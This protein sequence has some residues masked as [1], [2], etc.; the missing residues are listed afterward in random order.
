MLSG[1]VFQLRPSAPLTDVTGSSPLLPTP[2]SQSNGNAADPGRAD[3]RRQVAKAKHGRIFGRGLEESL[4]LLPTPMAR[5]QSGTQVSGDSRTGG[6]M[7]EEALKLLPTP[8][9]SLCNYGEEPETWEPRRAAAAERHGNN[10]IGMPLP[11]ALKLLPTP[12]A[13]DGT[14]GRVSRE[15][16]GTRDSGAKRAVTLA[17]AIHHQPRGSQSIGASTSPPSGAGKPSTG[18]RL[19]PLFPA[20]MMGTPSCG[21]CGREWTDPD[22]PHSATAFIPTSGVLSASTSSGWINKQDCNRRR[23][24]M[25]ERTLDLDLAKAVVD[26]GIERGGWSWESP[27]SVTEADIHNAAETLIKQCMAA[28]AN[29]SISPDVLDILHAGQVEPVSDVSREAYAQRFG[30]QLSSNGHAAQ[31]S[32]APSEAQGPDSPEQASPGPVGSPEPAREAAPA[33][34]PSTERINAIFGGM[35]YDDQKVKDIRE[36]VLVSAKSGDLSPEEWEQIKA[37]EAAHEERKTILSLEPEFVAP[38]PESAPQSLAEAAAL[39]PEETAQADALAAAAGVVRQP[40]TTNDTVI[41]RPMAEQTPADD[42]GTNAGMG[43]F[44]NGEAQSRAAQEGLPI[45]PKPAGEAPLLPLDITNTSDQELSRVATLF[46][47][48][49]A[50]TQWLISQEEGRE[51]AAEAME[52]ECHRDEFARAVSMHESAIPEDK[53]TASAVEN[54]R[55]QAAHDADAASTV[56]LWRNRKVRHGIDARM[57]KALAT[58]YDRAV[59]RITDEL[60]RRGAV[61]KNST[62][63]RPR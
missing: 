55:R 39:T 31:T 22:C 25:P 36:L 27:D 46:H 26:L 14:G 12:E 7:L 5:T 44:Y 23:E 61:A 56:R 19:N 8:N 2:T 45:P 62:A 50:H 9:A 43:A 60:S 51:R 24:H 3:E 41:I 15:K 11:I 20:W 21:E 30:V 58:G 35:V 33:E 28:T 59:W 4:T 57:L 10:G 34:G 13:S 16:G 1:T 32:P 54:A 6:P 18:L 53:R 38:E 48:H 42:Y 49:F 52:A 37:Y 40:A 17:T 47:S 29:N 63:T